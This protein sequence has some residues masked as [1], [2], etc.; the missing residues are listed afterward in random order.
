METRIAFQLPV[1]ARVT[2]EVYNLL[3]QKQKVLVNQEVTAGFHS[4]NWDGRDLNGSS[5][6]SG[7][8]LYKIQVTPKAGNSASFQQ[9]RKMLLLK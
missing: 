5:V 2:L 7:F 6:T 8:Y 3:G 1:A 4:I 9:V